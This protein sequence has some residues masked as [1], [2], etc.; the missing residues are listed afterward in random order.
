MLLQYKKQ[1]ISIISIPFTPGRFSSFFIVICGGTFFFDLRDEMKHEKKR[2]GKDI[3][4]DSLNEKYWKAK[5]LP[6]AKRSLKN[7]SRNCS[8]MII[9]IK[10]KFDNTMH[11]VVILYLHLT[12]WRFPDII[13]VLL[14]VSL[15]GKTVSR[16]QRNHQMTGDDTNFWVVAVLNERIEMFKID[17]SLCNKS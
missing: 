3:V 9:I 11:W 16:K 12:K 2:G 8:S 10:R 7:N 15:L 5:P 17:V 4:M 6:Q 14:V 13:I 1:E